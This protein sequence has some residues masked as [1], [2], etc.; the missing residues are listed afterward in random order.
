MELQP[1]TVEGGGIP[2]L[3]TLAVSHSSP[4]YV[5]YHDQRSPHDLR[6]THLNYAFRAGAGGTWQPESSIP[7]KIAPVEGKSSM[8]LLV[9]G[10]ALDD[11]VYAL[12][13]GALQDGGLERQA[14]PFVVGDPQFVV[15]LTISKTKA[16]I[17]AEDQA[18]WE[19]AVAEYQHVLQIAPEHAE[20]QKKL[21]LLYYRQQKYQTAI[22][23]FTYLLT[24]APDMPGIQDT[25]LESYLY[26][27][28]AAMQKQDHSSALD[29]LAQAFPIAE[30]SNPGKIASIAGLQAEIYL[31]QGNIEQG[32][33]AAQKAIEHDITTSKPYTILAFHYLRQGNQQEALTFLHEAAQRG[34]GPDVGGYL[35]VKTGYGDLTIPVKD[36][37]RVSLR[38][39]STKYNEVFIG[40][41]Q[42]HIHE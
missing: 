25:L 7:L 38:S 12:H 29:F 41:V 18:T 1:E 39:V 6:L 42:F 10:Q 16:D 33:K 20:L 34:I 26:A 30:Q 2:S 23:A 22:E 4:S 13:F 24:L 31:E 19:Q 28:Q 17:Y 40:N 8:Y 9:T 27:A 14:Y 36:M 32:V 3:T 11:G 15:D 37:T 21:A 35:L 5:L